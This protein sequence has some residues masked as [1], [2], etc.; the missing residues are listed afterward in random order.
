MPKT[1]P[2]R[3]SALVLAFFLME[4]IYFVVLTLQGDPLGAVLHFIQITPFIALVGIIF[5]IF[6]INK[7]DSITK[8]I[9]KIT[10][11][12]GIIFVCLYFYLMFS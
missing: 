9:P 7:E 12:I 10:L 8:T 1:L 3:L 11:S 6:A 5:S 4:L 2:G